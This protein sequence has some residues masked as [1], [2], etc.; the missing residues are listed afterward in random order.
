MKILNLALVC[1]VL[2]SACTK[3]KEIEAPTSNKVQTSP[4]KK[5]LEKILKENPSL[6]EAQSLN[7]LKFKLVNDYLKS[8]HPLEKERKSIANNESLRSFLNE[9]DPLAV[10]F[11][12]EDVQ[13]I[14]KKI[15][16]EEQGEHPPTILISLVQDKAKIRLAELE[17]ISPIF[18]KEKFSFSESLNFY[19]GPHPQRA[20]S[21]LQFVNNWFSYLGALLVEKAGDNNYTVTQAKNQESIIKKE[22]NTFIQ[23]TLKAKQELFASPSRLIDAYLNALLKQ[24]DE[25]SA[26]I[27]PQDINKFKNSMQLDSLMLGLNYQ[28]DISGLT[29][30]EVSSGSPAELGNVKVDDKIIFIKQGKEE[31][32]FHEISKMTNLLNNLSGEELELSIVRNNQEFKVKITPTLVTSSSKEI[33]YFIVKEE[34]KLLAYIKIPQFYYTTS[35]DENR[36]DRKLLNILMKLSALEVKGIV[37][38]LRDNIG[39]AFQVTKTILPFFISAG[40]IFQERKINE[41]RVEKIQEH[42]ALFTGKIVVLI[43]SQSA[44]SA[45][46]IT[47]A[48]QDQGRALVAGEQ[49]F[50]KG[51]IQEI[52]NFP[53]LVKKEKY[54]KSF[55]EY[56]EN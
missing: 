4:Y 3:K 30:K 32:S 19:R 18:F 21:D 15:P 5:D 42:E 54:L 31:A 9:I 46:I 48:L 2:F 50:G 27:A 17:K 29:V 51:T 13:E 12:E 39:G 20:P 23:D 11:S 26:Y 43:N 24:Y 44:S 53:S 49:S 35:E 41:N 33:Q 56:A 8:R 14:K 28:I 34:N 36:L 25:H 55:E 10:L 16:K 1:L 7:E 47:A 22:V 40:P 52:I 38:D 37:L 6:L 45:E